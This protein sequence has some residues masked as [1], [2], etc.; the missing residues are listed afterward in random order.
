MTELRRL[1][2]NA[3][4]G[5]SRNPRGQGSQL[6]E[7]IIDAAT[8]ILERTGSEYALTLRG[9]AREVGI[10]VA[11]IGRHFDDLF[12]IIDAVTARETAVLH[13]RLTAATAS[14]D[15]SGPV[16]RLM[17]IC[18]AYLHYGTERPA[19][20]H[21]LL[22]RRSMDSWQ[23][24]DYNAPDTNALMR[25]SLAL[26]TQAIADCATA[27]VSASTDPAYDTLVLWFALDGLVNLTTAVA[28]IDWPEREQLLTDCVTRTAKLTTRPDS[29]RT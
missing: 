16:D 11:S 8:A 27:G 9:I 4:T 18:R 20:Y 22:G 6:R 23:E 17:A 14:P 2:A 10:A 28:S 21:M 26:A 15:A 19:R 25:S 3:R 7:D 24:R 29:P 12:D 13:Q 1:P 5:R